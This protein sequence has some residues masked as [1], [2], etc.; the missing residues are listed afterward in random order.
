M[1]PAK[2]LVST[3]PTLKGARLLELLYTNPNTPIS[4]CALELCLE[5]GVELEQASLHGHVPMPIPY[6]DAQT[7]LDIDKRLNQLIALKAENKSDAWD[8]EIQALTSYRRKCLLPNGH[9]SCF[10]DHS[11]VAYNRQKA[12]IHRLFAKAEADGHH[13]AVS[14]VKRRLRLGRWAV[15]EG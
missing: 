4:S 8:P 7:L 12:A 2:L 6:T 14:L 3:Y 9:I 11:N 1:E 13:E 10:P 15:Y 5:N